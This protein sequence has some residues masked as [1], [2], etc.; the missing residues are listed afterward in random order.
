MAFR[1]D[2]VLICKR[3]PNDGTTGYWLTDMVYNLAKNVALIS[4]VMQSKPVKAVVRM[5]ISVTVRMLIIAWNA[6]FCIKN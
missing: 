2:V 4:R 3:W 1:A 6:I 5:I